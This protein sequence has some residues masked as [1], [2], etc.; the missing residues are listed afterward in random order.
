M[1][2]LTEYGSRTTPRVPDTTAVYS[3][4][5]DA[6]KIFRLLLLAF[7]IQAIAKWDVTTVGAGG[8]AHQLHKVTSATNLVGW[9]IVW[10]FLTIMAQYE[11]TGT[12]ALAFAWLL[13]I[14]QLLANGE[15]VGN[16]IS[17]LLDK[18]QPIPDYGGGSTS[19]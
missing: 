12:L 3:E 8:N 14:A 7:A 4:T 2:R 1:P 19:H 18:Q 17:A 5:S 15:K 10:F 11:A 16:Q 6:T 9:L 13:L